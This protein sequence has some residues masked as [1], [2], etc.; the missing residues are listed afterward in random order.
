M[1]RCFKKIFSGFA[2]L[3]VGIYYRLDVLFKSGLI[4]QFLLTETTKSFDMKILPRTAITCTI[5]LTML[6]PLACAQN[7]TEDIIVQTLVDSLPQQSVGGLSVDALGYLYSTDFAERVWKINPYTG[8]VTVFADGL[9]GASGNCFDK[10]GNLY[11]SNID[12]YYISKISRDGSKEIFADSLIYG[13]VGITVNSKG[14]FFVCNCH[15]NSITRISP[16]GSTEIFAKSDYFHCPNGITAD[17]NDNLYV[18]SFNNNVIVKITPAGETSLF[19][20]TPGKMGNGHLTIVNGNLY[21][22]GF[23]GHDLYK[24]GLDNPKVE[25][26]GIGQKGLKDGRSTEAQ[27]SYPNGIASSLDGKTLFVNEMHGE[28]FNPVIM[29]GKGTIRAIKLVS[30]SDLVKSRIAENGLE[31][32]AEYYHELKQGRFSEVNTNNQL[33]SLAYNYMTT[34]QF[35]VAEILFRLNLGS[36]P[37]DVPSYSFLARNMYLSGQVEAARAYYKKALELKPES[38]VLQFRLRDLDNE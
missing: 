24:V 16:Q 5:F 18:V 15:A 33:R 4:R 19:A 2:I 12:G 29:P 10:Q 34:R 3:L 14:N 27:F 38:R 25:V 36:Y 9:Y 28:I 1:I 32:L 23:H 21:V 11:Q 17:A 7:F 26:I 6:F 8:A 13:P 35:K 30:L 20:R 37:D 22:T 31:N